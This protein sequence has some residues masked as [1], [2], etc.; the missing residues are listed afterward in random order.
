MKKEIHPH[1]FKIMVE[2]DC[3]MNRVSVNKN[4]IFV[5]ETC[6]FNGDRTF[7]FEKW[8]EREEQ[9]SKDKIEAVRCALDIQKLLFDKPIQ[10]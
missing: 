9:L 8:K 4:N 3:Q 7:D 5:G 2:Y 1:D 6:I 10:I